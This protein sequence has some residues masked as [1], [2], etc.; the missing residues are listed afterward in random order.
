MTTSQK[1]IGREPSDDEIRSALEKTKWGKTFTTEFLQKADE[2]TRI[3]YLNLPGYFEM[4]EGVSDIFMEA[5][6]TVGYSNL[7]NFVTELLMHRACGNYLASVRLSSS[8]QLPESYLQL[9]ACIES[10]LYAFNVYS[11][12]KLAQVWL[13]RHKDSKSRKES[14]KQFKPIFILSKLEQVNQSLERYVKSGY[15]LCIDSGAH[16]NERSVTTSLSFAGGKMALDLF[17]TTQEGI[18]RMCLSM[19]VTCGLD[20]IKIFN[21]IYPDDFKKFNAEERIQAIQAQ[22]Q[23]IAPEVSSKLRSKSP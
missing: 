19:C 12:P 1:P 13:D 9:R 21:L 16:P 3:T 4:L 5:S 23:R 7:S 22:F 18:F 6:D 8:G 17:N 14:S 15:E 20:T 11:D 10:A 2:N